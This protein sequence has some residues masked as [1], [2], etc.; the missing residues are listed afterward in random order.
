[1][2]LLQYTTGL[3]Q[4]VFTAVNTVKRRVVRCNHVFPALRKSTRGLFIHPTIHPTPAIYLAAARMKH[5]SPSEQHHGKKS[6]VSAAENSSTPPADGMED[7]TASNPR[8]L[9]Q[10]PLKKI[11]MPYK[12]GLPEKHIAQRKGA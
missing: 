12:N 10:N 3:K 1:M 5:R 8:E 6:R 11:W 2:S 4:G 9:T 7:Q